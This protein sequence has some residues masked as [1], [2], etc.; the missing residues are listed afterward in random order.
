M[1]DADVCDLLLQLDD[2]H[3]GGLARGWE[4]DAVQGRQ[5]IAAAKSLPGSA[6]SGVARSTGFCSCLAYPD[7]VG[8]NRQVGL[9]RGASL[10]DYVRRSLQN[11][12]L[13]SSITTSISRC[14]QQLTPCK[15]LF[16]R[17]FVAHLLSL[18]S[19]GLLLNCTKLPRIPIASDLVSRL[20]C[21]FVSHRRS[22]PRLTFSAPC[23]R[24]SNDP[25]VGIVEPGHPSTTPH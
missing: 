21:H 7:D 22:G 9:R 11:T 14:K 20:G 19:S 17:D 1:E 2:V 12:C 23:R 3:G 6:S 15:T 8:R 24:C 5:E 4:K 16:T 13:G 25:I 10:P 18:L